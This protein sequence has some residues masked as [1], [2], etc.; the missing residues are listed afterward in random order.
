MHLHA[1]AYGSHR[2]C[3]F[4]KSSTPERDRSDLATAV[5]WNSLCILPKY[6]AFKD[7]NG[8]YL[9]PHEHIGGNIYVQSS[10]SDVSDPGLK[11]E[12]LSTPDGHIRIRNVPYNKFWS[13]DPNWIMLKSDDKTLFWPVKVGDS[14]VAL[15]CKGNN[16]F[17]KSITADGKDDCL[18]ACL[19]NITDAAKFEVT[20]LVLSRDIYNTNFRLSDARI[21]N[22][23]PIVVTSG[24]VENL[25]DVADKV[26]VK[27]SYEDTVTKTWSSSVS[28]KLGVKVTLETG[29]PLI[30]ESEIEIS[31][32]IGEEHAWG[33]TQQNKNII[34]VTHDIIVAPR[35]KVKAGIMATQATC[36]VPFS[37]TQRDR[38]MDGRAVIQRLD[39][40][41]FTGINSYNFQF[42]AEEVVA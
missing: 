12:I 21:Y 39:D 6:V 18:N 9:R 13:Y 31:A 4:A 7:E 28:T 32:E 14:A 29:V 34:E 17:V 10:G 41:I 42:V 26:S 1:Q 19:T 2:N 16:H 11:H 25:K 27:L 37:Y 15:R 35:S 38:L 23:K 8:H 24:V 20:E 40:G 33:E 36:D 3:V 30:G 5:D 22:E